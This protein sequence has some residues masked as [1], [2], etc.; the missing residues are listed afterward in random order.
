MYSTKQLEKILLAELTRTQYDTF[1]EDVADSTD[2][3][4]REIRNVR[5]SETFRKVF[6]NKQRIWIPL[7][8]S[9][10]IETS[11]D[12][13]LEY[14]NIFREY[15]N[16]ELDRY[17][18]DNFINYLDI[19][20]YIS[21]N[22]DSTYKVQMLPKAK[23][24]LLWIKGYVI[25]GKRITKIGS[26]I[27]KLL[28]IIKKSETI[29]TKDT[30]ID[31]LTNIL[32]AFN[33]RDTDPRLP[34]E[35]YTAGRSVPDE[36]VFGRTIKKDPLYI[37]I[38]RYPADVAA[39]STRQGWRSCQDL[40][41]YDSN[42][43]GIEYDNYNWHVK[44]DIT[45]GTCIAYII[46]ESNIRK[47]KEKQNIPTK[48]D[49]RFEGK[50]FIP[51]TSLFPILSPIARILIKPFYGIDKDNK[52]QLYL[53]TGDTPI[54]Y[55]KD[56]YY[57]ILVNTTRKYVES[58]Q[59]DK[60]G[61]F[62]LPDELYNEGIGSTTHHGSGNTL[63][64][65]SGRIVD[66]TGSNT[67][68]HS[69]KDILK[70]RFHNY[71]DKHGIEAAILEYITAHE[72]SSTVAQ[73]FIAEYY[74]KIVK[75][76]NNDKEIRNY[77]VNVIYNCEFNFIGK[78]SHGNLYITL[79]IFVNNVNF[80]N[81]NFYT[82]KLLETILSTMTEQEKNKLDKMV[83]QKLKKSY[84]SL[85]N[86]MAK[87]LPNRILFE[88]DFIT[89]IAPSLKSWLDNKIKEFAKIYLNN[90]SFNF[91]ISGYGIE[92]RNTLPTYVKNNINISNFANIFITQFSQFI[93]NNYNEIIQQNATEIFE[94]LSA[95]MND[96][97]KIN[98]W[99][100]KQLSKIRI[101][102]RNYVSNFFN[103]SNVEYKVNLPKTKVGLFSN[104]YISLT[105]TVNKKLF[106]YLSISERNRIKRK[107][108][109]SAE[110]CLK[111][112]VKIYQ[113][114]PTIDFNG[115]YNIFLLFPEL[116]PKWKDYRAKA[117]GAWYKQKEKEMYENRANL[118]EKDISQYADDLKIALQKLINQSD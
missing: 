87:N 53:S 8:I 4:Y 41:K 3:S 2:L 55:G 95:I 114:N 7:D 1:M 56:T 93:T 26:H 10:E 113:E 59:L 65:K 16:N 49:T 86:G 79:D 42:G 90:V 74:T 94:N 28:N 88:N 14:E 99:W 108:K 38:S 21:D 34:K 39:M 91:Y 29:K 106:D 31:E 96:I 73:S 102:Q 40:S 110:K 5:N 117:F 36:A 24:V 20:R 98:N 12:K 75:I 61:A 80:H 32:K 60:N 47:S 78:Y 89:K 85:L 101:D 17:L 107:L 64:V 50:S 22:K 111:Q 11:A 54:L 13:Y 35:L 63:I 58:R 97:P 44:Y 45:L 57:D 70:R 62:M 6:G 115:L 19:S 81:E 77:L 112:C 33:S 68:M 46:S 82:L 25:D 76:L 118:S 103:N 27:N 72:F 92:V 48:E 83:T 109:P 30:L 15:N 105:P 52:G 69:E 104:P 43:N 23:L 116:K 51:K 84:E 9:E 18:L 100:K 67:M 37:C 66:I 71:V